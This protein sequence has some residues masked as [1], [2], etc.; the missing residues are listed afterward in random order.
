MS[1]NNKEPGESLAII[2]I[3]MAACIVGWAVFVPFAGMFS[4]M[5]HFL[6]H[7]ISFRPYYR[8]WGLFR[9]FEINVD[10][11]LLVFGIL[12]GLVLFALASIIRAINANT[13]ELKQI[14]E[15]LKTGSPK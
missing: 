14:K 5:F 3:I 15:N 4:R 1:T 8:Q 11:R 2:L 6:P 13:R 10:T 9:S 7:L 12:I